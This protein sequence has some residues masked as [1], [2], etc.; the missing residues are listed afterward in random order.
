MFHW[1]CAFKVL[2]PMVGEKDHELP[3]LELEDGVCA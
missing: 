3:E 1:V 2:N